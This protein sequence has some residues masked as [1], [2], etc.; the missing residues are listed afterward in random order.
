MD[1][2]KFL[3]TVDGRI[4]EVCTEFYFNYLKDEKDKGIAFSLFRHLIAKDIFSDCSYCLENKELSDEDYA[5]CRKNNGLVEK[6]VDSLIEKGVTEDE[7]YS[8]IW[9]SVYDNI[10][11]NSDEDKIGILFCLVTNPKIP[12]FQ[13]KKPIVTAEEKDLEKIVEK[14]YHEAQ[15][16]QFIMNMDYENK[17]ETSVHLISLLDT[18]EDN[19]GK[20]VVL[21][22]ALNVLYDRISTLMEILESLDDED[23]EDDESEDE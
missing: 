9:T 10:V 21:V 14:Y 8:Q 2:I 3:Q 16:G 15:K 13:M 17:L 19:D 5:K 6:A 11:F 23:E 22:G 12:Y 4:L 20:S 7:F 1:G 18:I